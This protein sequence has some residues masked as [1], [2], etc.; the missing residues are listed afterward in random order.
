MSGEPER[1]LAS[2]SWQHACEARGKCSIYCIRNVGRAVNSARDSSF[3]MCWSSWF[4]LKEQ[5]GM[6]CISCSH[7]LSYCSP[8]HTTLPPH[9]DPDDCW[10]WVRLWPWPPR[11]ARV[12]R[13]GGHCCHRKTEQRLVGKYPTIVYWQVSCC[14]CRLLRLFSCNHYSM[15]LVCKHL[16]LHTHTAR[17]CTKWYVTRRG[18]SCQLCEDHLPATNLIDTHTQSHTW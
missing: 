9:I 1:P 8:S 7:L 5:F 4:M 2:V 13:G 14:H 12:Y 3:N 16:P 18:V 10:S 17:L 11:W 6:S 15:L